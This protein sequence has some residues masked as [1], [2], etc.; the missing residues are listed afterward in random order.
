MAILKGFY[1]Q[2]KKLG[3][4]QTWIPSIVN[5]NIIDLQSYFLKI[6]MM[7]N[8]QWAM[9]QPMDLNP[10]SKLWKKISS[11]ELLCGQLW[12]HGSDKVSCGL[13]YR[14]LR[15]KEILNLDI[16][17]S[18][19]TKLALWAY[20]FDGVYVCTIVVYSWYFS[21]D[22]WKNKKGFSSLM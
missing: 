18:K 5:V 9:D 20:R 8:V 2:P 1:Y 11:D 16:H 17:E 22:W 7:S 15:I 13:N 6:T 21:L 10:M 4:T 12:V 3:S 19:I 14:I